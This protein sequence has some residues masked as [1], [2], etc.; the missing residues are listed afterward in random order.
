VILIEAR[1]KTQAIMSEVLSEA[2]LKKVKP[3]LDFL[4]TH[5][6]ITP[7]EARDVTGKSAAT[8]RRYLAL[9]CERGI[10]ESTGS[11]NAVIYKI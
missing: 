10:L 9:L 6:A 11:T 4:G 2:E 7:Q 3:I 8:A 1:A 5:S